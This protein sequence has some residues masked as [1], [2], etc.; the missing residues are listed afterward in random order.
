MIRSGWQDPK[1]KFLEQFDHVLSPLKTSS[2]RCNDKK[3][4]LG[5]SIMGIL[6]AERDLST[7]LNF[8]ALSAITIVETV[9]P[10]K[11]ANYALPSL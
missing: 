7:N 9:H 3:W 8:S 6:V 1:T 4:I 10:R 11:E 2:Q 5:I